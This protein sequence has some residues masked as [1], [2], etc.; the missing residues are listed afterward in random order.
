MSSSAGSL[1]G[2]NRGAIGRF[3]CLRSQAQYEHVSLRAHVSPS[4][5]AHLAA[6]YVVS[7]HGGKSQEKRPPLHMALRV[8]DVK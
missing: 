2:S 1:Q 7:L 5:I 4:H 3:V 6:C 8:L